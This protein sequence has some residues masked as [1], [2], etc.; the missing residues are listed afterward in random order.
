MDSQDGEESGDVP[1]DVTPDPDIVVEPPPPHACVFPP[2]PAP[3]PV[4]LVDAFPGLVF[5][6]PLFLTHR[7]DDSNQ[8]FVV[9]QDGRIRV[10]DNDPGATSANTFL[11]IGDLLSYPPG[12]TAECG[13][14]GLAFHPNADDPA[15]VFVNY[16]TNIG[17]AFRT[18]VSRWSL[19]PDDPDVVDPGSE[20]V[21]IEI[22]QPYNNHNGGMIA[23]GPDGHL[24]IG[25]GDGGSAGDPQGN[26]QNTETLLGAMLR[27]DIDSASP[28]AIPP[29][30]PLVGI[31]GRDE[32]HAWGLRNPWRFSFDPVTDELWTGDVGQKALEEVDIIVRGGNY[33]WDIVEGTECYQA[34]NCNIEDF[35][36]P[37]LTYPQTVGKSITGG[38]VYRGASVPSLYGKYVYA[39]YVTKLVFAWEKDATPPPTEP[40]LISPSGISSF[41][42][43]AAGELYALGLL[44]GKVRRFV[45]TLPTGGD[46]LPPTLSDTGCFVDAPSLAPLGGVHP[47]SVSAPLWSDGASKQRWVAVP[48]GE[49]IARSVSG[50]L[51]PPPETVL[52]KHFAISLDASETDR[53]L[54][55]RFLV[56]DGPGAVRGYTYRWNPEG[57]EAH[58]LKSGAAETLSG[59]ALSEELTWQYPSSAQCQTCHTDIS[60]G[61]LGFR[62][63][64]LQG[65]DASGL[66]V[67]EALVTA[68]AVAPYAGPLPPAFADPSDPA[69]ELFERARSY[70][71]ANCANCHQPSGPTPTNLDLRHGTPV[72][73]MEACDVAPKKGDLGVDG[74][75]LLSPGSPETSTLLDRMLALPASGHRMPPLG[76]SQIDP[77]GT[78]VIHDWID[79]LEQCP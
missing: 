28:Y 40:L 44:D 60:G 52:I 26:G 22:N 29:D 46:P 12:Y 69:A 75:I 35:I 9:E 64:Q 56:V 66:T 6:K 1:P 62:A 10:F 78:S 20:S 45:E 2:Q 15:P 24:Y 39:D 21:V 63:A 71:D 25:M 76:S 42:L 57:T 59:P 67:L 19:M 49:P 65:L 31:A 23:F 54:E 68:G 11:D 27:I 16:T 51:V 73:D 37:V 14:L 7:P 55:T 58:L 48:H 36:A 8:L 61:V 32:I 79:T 38:A 41:G 4:E 17:G 13:L 3:E 34:T 18:V 53:K 33:G 50:D 5:S 74:A 47:Y 72:G 43:D 77:L 70:L 30:N